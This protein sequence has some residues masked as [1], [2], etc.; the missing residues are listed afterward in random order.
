MICMTNHQNL[1][2]QICKTFSGVIFWFINC[3]IL[4]HLETFVPVSAEPGKVSDILL[5]LFIVWLKKVASLVFS[6]KCTKAVW[7]HKCIYF[8]SRITPVRYFGRM[9]Y[10]NGLVSLRW[11][12]GGVLS[13]NSLYDCRLPNPLISYALQKIWFS[14]SALSERSLFMTRFKIS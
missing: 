11:P 9:R 5:N 1:W 3:A 4:K 7:C 13:N 6:F 8:R 14:G 12:L 10:W 2:E